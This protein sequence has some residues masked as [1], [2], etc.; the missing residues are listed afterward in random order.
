MIY[1][2]IC[3]SRY[4]LRITEIINVSMIVKHLPNSQTNATTVIIMINN[5]KLDGD[6]K[7]W[8]EENIKIKKKKRTTTHFI[9][10]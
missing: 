10:S 5:L 4:T 7:K 6:R 2:I 3:F 1:I 8:P 9:T